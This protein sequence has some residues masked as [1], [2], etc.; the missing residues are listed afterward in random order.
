[1][2]IQGEWMEYTAILS[3]QIVRSVRVKSLES[4]LEINLKYLTILFSFFTS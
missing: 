2:I 3:N 4:G 1:M